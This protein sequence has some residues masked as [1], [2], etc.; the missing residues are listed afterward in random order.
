MAKKR[1]AKKKVGKKPAGVTVTR[2]NQPALDPDWEEQI[3]EPVG[4]AVDDYV[5]AMRAKNKATEK[6]RNTKE[7]CIDRM[8]EHGITAVRIDEGEKI[9]KLETKHSL[10]TAKPKKQEQLDDAE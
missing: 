1:T 8:V 9:L 6:V 4:A 10:K 2:S 5:K 3:P 7:V